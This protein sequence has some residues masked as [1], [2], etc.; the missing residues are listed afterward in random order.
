MPQDPIIYGPNGKPVDR[1][2]VEKTLAR[3]QSFP[4]RNE[5]QEQIAGGLSPADLAS[6]YQD[7]ANIDG[8]PSRFLNFA[9]ELEER[10]GHYAGV[11]STR[12]HAV[13]GVEYSFVGQDKALAEEIASMLKLVMVD[14]I[15]ALLDGIGKGYSVVK[16]LWGLNEKRWAITGFEWV[17]PHWL[18]WKG[19]I[20]M[21][22][23]A[24]GK[25]TTDLP[26]FTFAVHLPRLKCGAPI[27]GGLARRCGFLHLA[28]SYSLKD[29]LSLAR[30]YGMPAP[31]GQ[32]PRGATKEEIDDLL[33]IVKNLRSYGGGVY[34]DDARVAF[35]HSSAAANGK[36]MFGDLFEMMNAEMSKAVLGQVGTSDGGQG[37]SK[38]TEMGKVRRDILEHDAKAL[39]ITLTRWV[40]QPYC[41]LNYGTV[42]NAPVVVPGISSIEDILAFS[43]S[44][45][46]LVDVGLPIG[47]DAVYEHL[48]IRPAA[49]G[50]ALLTPR[51]A[52]GPA[53][54]PDDS[55]DNEGDDGKK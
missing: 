11:L 30:V 46:E 27:R 43:R 7:A 14:A 39:A 20:P 51:V 49:E 4:G 55:N 10:D 17:D 37:N 25:K 45:G 33:Q 48:P 41:W 31:T 19:N 24:D 6:I 18:R 21:L 28:K 16:I 23:S 8:D 38:Q 29:W 40:V 54:S 12:K 13:A 42:E 5:W 34:P 15:D 1:A 3:S 36:S 9:E 52:V 47:V 50:E 26:P 44:V 32:Y 35:E 2:R 22:L 53:P